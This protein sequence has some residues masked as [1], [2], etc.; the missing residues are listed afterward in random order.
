VYPNPFNA[1]FI[2][3]TTELTSISVMNAMG[4]VVLSRTVNGRTS[5]NATSLSAGIYFIREETSGA[6][7]KLVKN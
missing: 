2:I 6:V 1:E 3:E 5:I 4:E 7:M